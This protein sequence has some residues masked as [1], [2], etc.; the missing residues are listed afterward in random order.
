MEVKASIMNR[1]GKGILI[2]KDGT[3]IDAEGKSRNIH[4]AGKKEILMMRFITLP[5]WLLNFLL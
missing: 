1:A 2:Q 5:S 3:G 4:A